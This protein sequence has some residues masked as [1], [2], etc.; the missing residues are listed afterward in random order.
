[1]PVPIMTVLNVI[2]ALS[3]LALFIGEFI[4]DDKIAKWWRKLFPPPN[5]PDKRL[6]DFMENCKTGRDKVRLRTLLHD[7][8]F[9][10]NQT[11]PGTGMDSIESTWFEIGFWTGLWILDLN[12]RSSV[13]GKM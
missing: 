9:N 3:I 13:A 4:R 1:M 5:P 11:E 10:P 6:V 7:R 8:D 2:H 12:E